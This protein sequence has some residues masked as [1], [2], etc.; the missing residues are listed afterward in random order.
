MA[1]ILAASVAGQVHRAGAA[2]KTKA[3]PTPTPTATATA[4]P[5]PT[6]TPAPVPTATPTPAATPNY[7]GTQQ[8]QYIATARDAYVALRTEKSQPFLDAH[9]ALD[10]AGSMSTKGLKTKEDIAAR[11]DLIA[12]TSAANDA[13][14]EFVKTQEDTYRAE[15]AKTPLIPAD[16]DSLV[17]E[18]AGKVNT[19]VN[20]KLR[21]TERDALKAGDAMLAQ[22]DKTFGTWTSNDAGKVSFKK[23][24]DVSAMNALSVKFN[25]KV[26]EL[27]PLR[28]QLGQA[29]NA[30]PASGPVATPAATASPAA[31]AAPAASAKP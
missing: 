30:T 31:T 15:L 8:G 1:F 11:R 7:S 5:T 25:A 27:Q 13:Y 26:S 4:T 16:V 12:K 29:A 21:E 20:I 17:K 14:L 24:A 6:P 2:P 10:A 3:T 23:K 18:Y 22:L 28:E 19:P 9:R